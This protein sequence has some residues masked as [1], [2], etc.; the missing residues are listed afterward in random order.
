MPTRF[1]ARPSALALRLLAVAALVIALLAPVGCTG[2]PTQTGEPETGRS[3]ITSVP[4]G[5]EEAQPPAG[6]EQ[7]GTEQPGAEPPTK[8]P[9]KTP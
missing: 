5:S 2:V 1:V 9:P 8:T 3:N 7:S 6:E 4:P